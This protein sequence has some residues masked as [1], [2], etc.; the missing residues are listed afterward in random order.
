MKNSKLDK[1][2]TAMIVESN[3]LYGGENK[4]D[5]SYTDCY[6]TTSG[7]YDKQWNSLTDQKDTAITDDK[8]V[9]G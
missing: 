5:V 9:V 1:F 3:G 6:N 4:S 2:S 7:S 8:P